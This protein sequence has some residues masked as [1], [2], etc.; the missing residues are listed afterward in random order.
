MK[1]AKRI[2]TVCEGG[3]VRSVGLAYALKS[4]GVDAI[5]ASW[6][7]NTKHTLNMLYRWADYIVVLQDEMKQHIPKMYQ[8]KLRVMDVG[9]DR[10]GSAFHP[11]LQGHFHAYMLEWQ[12]REFE[13]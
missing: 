10:Y 7:F 3:N 2:L 5:A 11:E 8:K 1:R 13:L 4:H 6:R 12:Q 9:P